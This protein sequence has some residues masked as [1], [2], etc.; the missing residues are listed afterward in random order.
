VPAG[1]ERLLCLV[2]APALGDSAQPGLSEDAIARCQERS[3]D[4]LRRC[5]L[6]VALEP[7]RTVRTTPHDFHQRFPA[8][9]GALYGQAT[10]GWLSIF[11]RPGSACPVP[12]LF[13]AG[14]SAHPGPG[15]PMAAMSG[16]LAAE[17]VVEH[18]ASTRRLHPVATSGG[19]SMPSAMTARWGSP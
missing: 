9:G 15:V 12:G 18:L 10:H 16:R 1:R 2:N 11:S 19:T 14:G 6:D 4:W 5:G 8:T 7:E 3:F 13:L 17:A